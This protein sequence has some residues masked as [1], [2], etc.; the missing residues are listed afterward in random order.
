MKLFLV[1]FIV[2][3][4]DAMDGIR[5]IFFPVVKID[6]QTHEF[7]EIIESRQWQKGNRAQIR[8]FGVLTAG[9]MGECRYHMDQYRLTAQDYQQAA[10]DPLVLQAW[11]ADLPPDVRDI[12][13]KRFFN[14]MCFS[15]QIHI[16]QL[17]ESWGLCAHQF[18]P[19]F[20]AFLKKRAE[21]LN[22]FELIQYLLKLQSVQR[23]KF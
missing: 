13:V 23:A 5:S 9:S 14:E 8:L 18:E 10:Q 17:L 12:Q 7:I 4:I 21:G 2:I 22:Y 11:L 3:N 16:L 19:K 20:L 15:N 1:F 6:K